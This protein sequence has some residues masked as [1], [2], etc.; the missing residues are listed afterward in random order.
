MDEQKE[1]EEAMQTTYM[2]GKWDEDF[3]PVPREE[4]EEL[5]EKSMWLDALESAG[6]DNWDGI[7]YAQEIYDEM[8][9]ATGS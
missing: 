5:V 2:Y 6:V 8:N 4:Y 7:D 1:Y 9:S 3:V